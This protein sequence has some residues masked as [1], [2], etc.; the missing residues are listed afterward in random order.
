MSA[1]QVVGTLRALA[2]AGRTVVLSIH[3]PRSEIWAALDRVV[4]LA[5]GGRV[6]FAGERAEAL[7]HFARLGWPAPA[8]V[9]PADFL[10]D[11]AAV[12]VRSEGAE[13]E[14]AARVRRLREAWLAVEDERGDRDERS[15]KTVEKMAEVDLF[16]KTDSSA[17]LTK[18]T[19]LSGGE[20]PSRLTLGS[21]PPAGFR[22]QVA[23]LTRRTFVTTMRDP[24]GMAAVL[25]EAIVM[26]IVCG[27]IY[28]HLATDLTGI[29]SRE[30]SLYTT[31]SLNGYLILLYETFRLTLDVRLFDRERADG[32]VGA[33][34]WIISRRASRF[35]LED[36]PSPVIFGTIF[37]WMAGYRADAAQFFIF[38]ALSVL[39]H[40]TAVAFASVCIGAAR[41]F[42]TASFI[43]NLSFTLQ[44]MACGFFIQADQIPVYVRWLKW[45]AY[46]FYAFGAL[47]ANEFIGVGTDPRVGHF[48]DCPYSRNP[49]DPRCR[50][51]TGVFIMESLGLPHNWIWRPIVVLVAFVLGFHLLGILLLHFHRPDVV[52][53]RGNAGDEAPRSQLQLPPDEG[54]R[55]VTDERQITVSLDGLTL[56]VRSHALTRTGLTTRVHHILSPVHA[57]FPPGRLNVIM[58]PSGSGKT[59]LLTALAGRFIGS[60]SRRVGGQMRYN[61]AVP[62]PLVIAAVSSLVGQDDDA[63]MPSLTVRETLRYAAALR[64]PP[65]VSAAA[66]AARAEE[67]LAALGL[68]DCADTRIGSE[69]EGVRGVSGGEKRRVS[70]AIQIL[71]DPRVLLV[72]EPTSGL[73]AFTAAGIIDVLAALAAEGRTVIATIHQSRSD[74]W[75]RFDRVLLLARGGAVVY[76]GDGAGM[77]PYFAAC[78]HPCPPDAN[79]ADFALDLITVDLQHPAREAATRARVDKLISSWAGVEQLRRAEAGCGLDSCPAPAGALME[80]AQL[81]SLKKEPNPFSTVFPVLLR[82]SSLNFFRQ[83]PLIQARV[84]QGLGMVA[85]VM[86]FFSPLKNDYAGVQSRVGAVQQFASFYFVGMSTSSL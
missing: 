60:H 61:G 19:A 80:P 66:K 46:T 72:D 52:V 26:A 28:L 31:S 32:V 15:G 36:I 83:W 20:P 84:G 63:L 51:Y 16:L 13:K 8:Y 12:D 58:G 44:T 55:R 42:A 34:A 9:N 79:P 37:Y 18:E 30:G 49:A 3:A 62:S 67:V 21:A 81:G 41:T 78:A 10:V 17:R 71:T 75:P 56:Q 59:T 64:L 70:V 33:A 14:S 6:L 40:Y 23:V 24:L 29:R 50:Q 73:D 4:L 38:L 53:A 11:V 86:L 5:R 47:A 76:A 74:L 69:A 57:T 1:L 77:V 25:I 45:L 65:H 27:W 22:R 39:I 7:P 43:A 48:Y 35:L 54:R 85:I 2:H 68:K 82:R